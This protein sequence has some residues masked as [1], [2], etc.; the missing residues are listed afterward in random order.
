MFKGDD[1]PEVD[2]PIGTYEACVQEFGDDIFNGGGLVQ[3]KA[4]FI[5]DDGT[6][7][8]TCTCYPTISAKPP[9]VNGNVLLCFTSG[10]GS[11]TDTDG[12]YTGASTSASTIIGNGERARFERD[13]D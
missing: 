11:I 6:I 9:E 3:L 5:F 4:R 7:S 13:R 1:D 10:A 8:V 2:D 12:V